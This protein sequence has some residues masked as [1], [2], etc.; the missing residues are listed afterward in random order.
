MRLHTWFLQRSTRHEIRYGNFIWTIFAWRERY[1][2]Q[3]RSL[4]DFLLGSFRVMPLSYKG[5][6]RWMLYCIFSHTNLER[7]APVV[8]GILTNE[9]PWGLNEDLIWHCVSVLSSWNVNLTFNI[10]EVFKFVLLCVFYH[11]F[12]W[13]LRFL[14]TLLPDGSDSVAQKLPNPRRC[15]SSSG[16]RLVN[17]VGVA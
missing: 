4:T 2:I 3:P 17:Y 1:W 5:K 12:S 8:I 16:S 14:K 13:M 7:F 9:Q 10:I 11:T 6:V 15:T